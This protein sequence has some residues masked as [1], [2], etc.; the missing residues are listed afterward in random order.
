MANGE[1]IYFD[2]EGIT[3][4][5]VF[6]KTKNDTLHTSTIQHIEERFSLSA[7]VWYPIL[8]VAGMVVFFMAVGRNDLNFGFLIFSALMVIGG[9]TNIVNGKRLI[10]KTEGK[11]VVIVKDKPW[12]VIREIRQALEGAIFAKN[13]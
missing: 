13:N 10:A 6:I 4:T 7:K 3:I 5:N 9:T 11:P 1:K 8:I 12:W 2:K